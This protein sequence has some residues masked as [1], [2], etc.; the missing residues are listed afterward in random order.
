MGGWGSRVRRVVAALAATGL[1]A[2]CWWSQPGFNGHRTGHHPH[3]HAISAANASSL[4]VEWTSDEDL[5]SFEPIH[6]RAGL[7]HLVDGHA[8]TTVDPNSGDTV[9]TAAIEA[10]IL[11]V[12]YA[13]AIGEVLYVP[14]ALRAAAPHGCIERFDT[15]TG[16]E[17][18]CLPYD[19]PDPAG[20]A[21]VPWLEVA[22]SGPWIAITWSLGSGAARSGWL[23]IV[24]TTDPGRSWSV[25]L[26]TDAGFE[27][28]NPV[29]VGR[30]VLA[31]TSAAGEPSVLQR[32]PLHCP[33]GACAPVASLA[34]TSELGHLIAADASGARLAVMSH[35]LVEVVDLEANELLWRAAT[36]AGTVH[37][38]SSRPIWTPQSLVVATHQPASSPGDT[39]LLRFPAAGCGAPSCAPTWTAQL[40]GFSAGHV[41]AADVLAIGTSDVPLAVFPDACNDPCPPLFTLDG[42]GFWGAPLIATGRIFVA[43]RFDLDGDDGEKPRWQFVALAPPVAP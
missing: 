27:V 1:L 11:S 31:V 25:P 14:S 23:S 19:A 41:A 32:W 10:P 6:S 42:D 43:G 8:V 35:D 33:T 39:T 24:H 15:A 18:G 37:F 4:E 3:E 21:G 28:G 7:L 12:P 17:L 22:A 20:A 26:T 13:V 9:W 16:A 34:L 2:G 38:P 30:T 29:I 5:L 36:P 40:E